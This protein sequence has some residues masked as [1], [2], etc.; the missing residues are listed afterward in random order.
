MKV[1]Y[2]A[3]GLTPRQKQMKFRKAMKE[4]VLGGSI[5]IILAVLLMGAILF[6]NSPSYDSS[7]IEEHA[8]TST[9]VLEETMVK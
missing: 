7:Y 8:Y 4:I 1:A 9:H 3:E 6:D 2:H 5:G